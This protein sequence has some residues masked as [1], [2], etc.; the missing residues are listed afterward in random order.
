MPSLKGSEVGPL[1]LESPIHQRDIRAD[2]KKAAIDNLDKATQE[3]EA[4]KKTSA[5][6]LVSALADPKIA[7]FKAEICKTIMDFAGW[8]VDVVKEHQAEC[9]GALKQ[10]L[11]IRDQPGMLKK[12]LEELSVVEEVKEGVD[13]VTKKKLKKFA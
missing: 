5:Y 9:R 8:P 10:W 2:K 1:V 13:E 11:M 12:Q 6:S 7:Y 4:L 3:W